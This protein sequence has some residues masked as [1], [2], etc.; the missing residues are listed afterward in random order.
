MHDSTALISVPSRARRPAAAPLSVQP[1]PHPAQGDDGH[2]PHHPFPPTTLEGKS[3]AC[4]PADV[5]K[6]SL[7]FHS[8]TTSDVCS[9][10]LHLVWSWSCDPPVQPYDPIRTVIPSRVSTQAWTGRWLQQ[11]LTNMNSETRDPLSSLSM[12]RNL[13]RI[14]GTPPI[15]ERL[16]ECIPSFGF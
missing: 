3:I 7:Y 1:P 12:T 5:S 15:S 6:C 14:F 16:G 2:L 11:T 8:V 10:L 13:S 4:D 9:P